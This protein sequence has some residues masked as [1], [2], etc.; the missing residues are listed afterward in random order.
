M[1]NVQGYNLPDDLYYSDKDL[2]AKIENGT[3]KIGIT[4]FAQAMLEKLTYL[5][6]ILR[7]DEEVKFNRPFGS[8]QAGKGWITLYSPL[9]GIITEVNE[10]PEDNVKILNADCYGE[11]WI[12]KITTTK[13]EEELSKLFKG[14]TPEFIKWQEEEIERVKKINEELKKK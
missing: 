10:A 5:D 2:W 14:G 3:A 8:I 1:V 4:D 9:S 6:V 11:G 13:L 12:I 7:E